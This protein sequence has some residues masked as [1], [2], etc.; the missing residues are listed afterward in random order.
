MRKLLVLGDY[1]ALFLHSA[2]DIL[3]DVMAELQERRC[4][5]RRRSS[6]AHPPLFGT[7]SPGRDFLG[8]L[9]SFRKFTLAYSSKWS[10]FGAFELIVL[11]VAW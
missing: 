3:R 6:E 2:S 11:F 4:G 10:T 1:F 9:R 8:R 5:K 7:Q